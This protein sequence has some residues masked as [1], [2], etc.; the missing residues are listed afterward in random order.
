MTVS[1]KNIPELLPECDALYSSAV[2]S[3]A[4]NANCSGKLVIT[5]I[6]GSN[7]NLNPLIWYRGVMFISNLEEFA[8]AIKNIGETKQIEEQGSDFFFLILSFKS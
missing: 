3:A 6:D 5:M 1:Q 8:E 7:F 2:T 4:V